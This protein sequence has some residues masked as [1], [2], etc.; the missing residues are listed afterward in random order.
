MTIKMPDFN[1]SLAWRE[2]RSKMG[3]EKT[4]EMPPIE[5]S[6]ISLHE[7]QKLKT[8]SISIDNILDHINPIDNTFDYKGQK[9][10]LYIK[11]Q[12]YNLEEFIR[13][14]YKFHISYCYTLDWM[15]KEKRFK[16]RYVVTQRL[17]GYF[18]I[19]IIQ[20]N[21]GTYYEENKL[22][23]LDI[24]KNCLSTLKTSYPNDSMFN[25]KNFNIKDFIKRYNTKHI[26]KPSHTPRS[27]PKDQYSKNWSKISK[28]L[29]E[30]ANY[31][32]DNCK[33]DCKNNKHL[34]HVHHKDGVKWNNNLDNLEVLCATCHFK[35]PGHKN[36]YKKVI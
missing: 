29:R 20:K 3:A 16:S 36:S 19:D 34:L 30:E 35:K 2:I 32:C 33:S 25:F 22:Y 15:E 5:I 10:L 27:I 4:F 7:I 11:Q 31:I 6:E 13:P 8:G 24:C 14:T 28:N 1:T 17:D 18:L 21:T 12:K 23:K 26:K 9:V